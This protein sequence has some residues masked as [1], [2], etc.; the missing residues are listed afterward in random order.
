MKRLIKKLA[1]AGATLSLFFCLGIILHEIVGAAYDD[2]TATGYTNIRVN[3]VK[4]LGTG[5]YDSSGNLRFTPG[6]TN[7]ITGNLT[8]SGTLGTTGATTQTGA[9]TSPYSNTLST[10]T[11]LG[12]TTISGAVSQSTTTMTGLLMLWTSA[13]PLTITPVR[14]GALIWNTTDLEVCVATG[15]VASSWAKIISTGTACSH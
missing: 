4:I 2:T 9:F 10:T 11:L 13:A 5:I 6:S 14:A 8:V 7:A 3:N 1:L 12:A 15:T